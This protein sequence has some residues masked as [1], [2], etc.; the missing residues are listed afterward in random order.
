MQRINLNGTWQL[1]YGPQQEASR[2]Q[3]PAGW[4]VIPASVP[5]NVE[6]DLV[7]A[8]AL[9][10]P[11][12]GDNIYRLRAYEGHEWWYR[13][14]FNAPALG[15]GQHA[16]LVFD[17]IDCVADI[18]LNGMLIGHTDN[19]LIPHQ[20]D[21]TG[22]IKTAQAG[23]DC[24]LIV[25]IHSAVL[26][27]RKQ[28]PEPLNSA[29]ATNWESIN[30]RKAPHMYGWDIMPR[31]VSAGLWR[32]VALQIVESSRWRSA[33][34]TTLRTDP[35]DRTATVLVDWDFV[36]DR[37]DVDHLRVRATV[38]QA[39]SLFNVV[40][41]HGR[42]QINLRD[43]DLWWPRGYGQPALYDATLELIDADGTVLDTHHARIGLRTLAL[44][45]TDVTT[46]E[47]PG[48]F[49]FVVNG[50]RIFVKGTNWVPLDAFHAR[51]PQHLG[52]Q[53]GMIA[54]LNC[55]MIRCWGG[56]VYEGHAF[57]DL[58][59]QLGV[60]VWQDFAMACAIYPQTDEFAARIRTEAEAI[61]L[62][63]R[64]HPSLALWAGN[65]EIDEAY[66][67]SSL[68]IDPNTDRLS[69]HVL[70]EVVRRLDPHRPY[71]PS[72]P[73]RSPAYVQR[74][75]S[76]DALP[77][78]FNAQPEQHLWGPRDDFKGPFYTRS[79]A[80]FASEIGY[81]GCPDRRSLEQFLDPGYVW[82]WQNNEQWLTH[83]TRPHP[84]MTDWNY[85]I[86]LM[87]KQ[88]GVLFDQV[89]DNLDDY[90]LASQISQA[91]AKKFFIEWFR[92]GKWRRTGILW[93]NL[94]DGW[95]I[96]S[97]AIVDYYGRRKLAYTYIKRVQ[98]D[99]CVI[100]CEP[101]DGRHAI[102]AV[103]DTRSPARGHAQVCDA[104]TQQVLLETNFTVDANDIQTIGHIAQTSRQAMWL[105]DWSAGG[106]TALRN[107]Y[108]VGHR[109]FKLEDYRRWL[110][111]LTLTS[112]PL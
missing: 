14:T 36:T 84:A 100:C 99:V 10:E 16:E 72:S 40:G 66:A 98:S 106:Q 109:P 95:P 29:F 104:D 60:L 83:A 101:R 76:I 12:I 69:R 35:A 102:I 18:W 11:S 58:C 4:P 111:M 31:A 3:P 97:D 44:R 110:D 34:W 30:V 25:R 108:L 80:H 57:F 96:I 105:I 107:H 24:E 8:G 94:R 49:V 43:V 17:G 53:T 63:L 22:V 47:Q 51:D 87:G 21:V 42:A 85:R 19:M 54:D 78:P 33:Y 79:L 81:H 48:E 93:W 2:T 5:G 28:P 39:V 73:Y 59:D 70:P 71:L 67:W 112:S 82:P 9:P 20:F 23:E 91:E 26:E 38:G 15:P 1:S 13:R 27:G 41:T 55:N 75:K 64:N 90:V 62:Q 61:V 32:D 77:E 56:N 37:I 6:L 7:A 74:Q 52:P 88:I 86:A 92:Q 103:N 65:N 68:S 50:E 89:P 46:P 45:Y